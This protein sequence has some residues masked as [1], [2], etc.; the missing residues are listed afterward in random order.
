MSENLAKIKLVPIS[1]AANFLGVSIDT[2]RRW[3]R[4]GVI[5]SQRPNG[6]DRYFSLKE[7]EKVKFEKPFSMIEAA[8]ALKI[9]VSTLRRL[10]KKG[11][12]SCR[13]KGNRRVYGRADLEKFLNSEYIPPKEG[14]EEEKEIATEKNDLPLERIDIERVNIK[15]WARIPELLGAGTVFVL[16]LGLGIR[17]INISSATGRGVGATAVN[18][19][20]DRMRVEVNERARLLAGLFSRLYDLRNASATLGT[21]TFS[22]SPAPTPSPEPK[23]MLT[24]KYADAKVSIN[25]REEPAVEAKIIGEAHD[26]DRFEFVSE[27]SGWYE[28][29]LPDGSTGFISSEYAETEETNN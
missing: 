24:V 13:R 6:K 10:E 1:K 17:N 20:S 9:S 26:G 15:P 19:L 21:A 11:V 12:I 5:H 3:D 22:A 7:L 4:Q 14:V 18:A 2:I 23:I 8:Q 29:K 16:L 27:N 28:V 25:I